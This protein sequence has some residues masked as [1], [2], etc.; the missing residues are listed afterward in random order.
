MMVENGEIVSVT[1]EGTTFINADG[2]TVERS[3]DEVDWD[4][5]E[6]EK[7]G[8][9]TFMLKEIHEQPDAVAETVADRV[10]GDHVDLGDIGISDDELEGHP[11]A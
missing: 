2:A 6:A 10:A 3:I 7:N 11:P 4:E 5:D 1:P 8:Y 9:D